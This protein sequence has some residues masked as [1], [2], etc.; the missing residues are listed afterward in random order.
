MH[1]QLFYLNEPSRL[2]TVT[3]TVAAYA[4]GGH[5]GLPGAFISAELDGPPRLAFTENISGGRAARILPGCPRQ[6]CAA[7]V[8]D[9]TRV[10]G[11]DGVVVG[12]GAGVDVE[13]GGVD[14]AKVEGTN[15]TDVGADGGGV[16][17]GGDEETGLE[18]VGVEGSGVGSGADG[19]G[20]GD[21]GGVKPGL[22][23]HCPVV[24]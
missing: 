14:G 6:D 8:A 12:Q 7:A 13:A 20:D 10:I 15:V 4:P 18:G 9:A 22:V 21:A 3:V 1:D 17:D 2:P 11:H 16:V 5:S 23:A 24:G 19:D